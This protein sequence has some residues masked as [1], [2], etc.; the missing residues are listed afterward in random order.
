VKAAP[1]SIPD[2]AADLGSIPPVFWGD[3][4]PAGKRAD[5]TG[6]KSATVSELRELHK[7]VVSTN[8][9]SL[10]KDALV[11]FVRSVIESVATTGTAPTTN[12]KRPTL[13]T[14][15]EYIPYR[16]TTLSGSALRKTLARDGMAVVPLPT[17]KT[18]WLEDYQLWL[19]DFA[20][21]QTL[22][23]EQYEDDTPVY[24]RNNPT[25]WLNK[26]IPTST[27]G[28]FKQWLAHTPFQWEIR[29]AC[30]QIF[31]DI[32]EC[33]PADLISSY[34]GG[35]V[36]FPGRRPSEKTKFPAWFHNDQPRTMP[37]FECWQGVVY[38]SASGVRD[39]GTVTYAGS[40]EVWTRY[41]SLRPSEGHKWGMMDT[42]LLE[43]LLTAELGA[44]R[45]VRYEVPQFHVFLFN[46]KV[47]HCS[48]PGMPGC[49]PRFALYVSMVPRS[50]LSKEEL[51]KKV[52]YYEENRMTSHWSFGPYFS[53]N[54]GVRIYNERKPVIPESPHLLELTPLMRRLAGYED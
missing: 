41:N 1:Y 4:I 17:F 5:S 18:S 42:P 33:S 45:I 37:D 48:Y 11:A 13:F 50:Y 53:A 7:L 29:E 22:E 12:L 49:D 3:G 40:K 24:D 32:Y 15:I 52:K 9:P 20:Q 2:L 21:K 34:D 44:A 54:G 35:S 38:L 26:N 39:P 47:A 30:A 8:P 6:A 36:T 46:S 23:R 25:T 28:I 16:G 19:E 10:K 31:A 51:A 27:R 14:E 43:E